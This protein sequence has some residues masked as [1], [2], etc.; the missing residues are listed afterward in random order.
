V[1]RVSRGKI[2]LRMGRIE[3]TARA[4]DGKAVVSVRDNGIG[5]PPDMLESV[6]GIFTQV[7]R[8][9]EKTRGG[10]GIGLSI[11]KR[12]VEM[13]GGTIEARSDG[14]GKG[15][16]FI[17]RLPL[18]LLVAG[19]GAAQA[20]GPARAE[21][22]HRCRVLIADDNLDAAA[23]LSLML[24]V[25]GNDVRVANDGLEA[26]AVA[27]SFHPDAILL[28]I[29]MPGVNGYDVCRRMR[30]RWGARPTIVALTGWG[31]E[32]DRH[33]SAEAGFDHHLVKPVEP[34]KLE[35]LLASIA[36]Q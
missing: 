21:S 3:L 5:I 33:R 4:D 2:E 16:E 13:H 7:D 25:M 23:S 26:L 31:Q 24:Q 9:L 14:P 10:L 36:R 12:L 32:E 30:E 35:S 27:E 6:F 11:A 34:G 29:G 20:P 18:A 15:S 1:S 22:P 28:D 8:S 19:E 17:V